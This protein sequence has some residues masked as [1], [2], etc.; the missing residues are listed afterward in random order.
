MSKDEEQTTPKS[1]VR[2]MPLPYEVHIFYVV[3][4]TLGLLNFIFFVLTL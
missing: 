1:P 2:R 4:H 3:K